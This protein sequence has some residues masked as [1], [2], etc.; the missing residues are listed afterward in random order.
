MEMEMNEFQRQTFILS[1]PRE[2]EKEKEKKK[3]IISIAFFT[4]GRIAVFP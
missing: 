4:A 2:K 1:L 3:K